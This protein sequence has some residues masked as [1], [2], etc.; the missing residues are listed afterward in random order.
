M[1]WVFIPLDDLMI[2]LFITLYIIWKVTETLYPKIA[3]N[4]NSNPINGATNLI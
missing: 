4:Q 3:I 2:P 1:D